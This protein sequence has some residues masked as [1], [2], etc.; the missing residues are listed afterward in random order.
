[1]SEAKR[2]PLVMIAKCIECGARREIKPGEI[3]PDDV[4]MCHK[5]GSVMVAERVK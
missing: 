4:P 5:C 1:M 2:R 3:A